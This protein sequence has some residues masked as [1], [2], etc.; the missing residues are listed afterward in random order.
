MK[1]NLLFTIF[2]LMGNQFYHF[3][4]ANWLE[5]ISRKTSPWQCYVRC[6]WLCL[7]ANQLWQASIIPSTSTTLFCFRSTYLLIVPMF[8]IAKAGISLLLLSCFLWWSYFQEVLWQV[9]VVFWIE[10]DEKTVVF[11]DFTTWHDEIFPARYDP[12]VTV[13]Y[14]NQQIHSTE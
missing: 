12:I 8:R 14:F 4:N 3:S 10:C 6:S 7:L 9:K 11:L 13:K 5:L 1:V 2:E